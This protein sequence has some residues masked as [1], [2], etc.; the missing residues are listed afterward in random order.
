MNMTEIVVEYMKKIVRWREM[1]EICINR[2]NCTGC[3]Y[4][5]SELCDK[6]STANVLR[7]SAD[8]FQE[9]LEDN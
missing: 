5:K 3:P 6:E 1:Y 7:S 4:K 2:P 9:F 8:I